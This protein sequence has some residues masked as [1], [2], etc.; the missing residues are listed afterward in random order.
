MVKEVKMTKVEVFELEF[1]GVKLGLFKANS[2]WLGMTELVSVEDP[3][4]SLVV[5]DPRPS[6][7]NEVFR[8]I[9]PE[10]AFEPASVQV[11][12]GSPDLLARMAGSPRPAAAR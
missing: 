6:T 1:G 9:F 11:V 3:K 12:M 4:L 8:D 2:R 5:V 7:L 10:E